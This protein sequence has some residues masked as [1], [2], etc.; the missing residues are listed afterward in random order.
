MSFQQDALKGKSSIIVDLQSRL[1][2]SAARKESDEEMAKL[3]A[4]LDQELVW[5]QG[6]LEK[7]AESSKQLL[8]LEQ[9]N[10]QL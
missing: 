3:R 5:L 4:V 1:E 9:K 6:K 2:E 10:S 8:E 7:T